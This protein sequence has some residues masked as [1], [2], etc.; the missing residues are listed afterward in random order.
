MMSSNNNLQLQDVLYDFSME[1]E[2]DKHTL[3]R[4]VE[5]Y[6]QFINELTELSHELTRADIDD[7][8]QLTDADEKLIEKA[9]QTHLQITQ[10]LVSDPFENISV[11]ELRGISSSLEVPRS[12]VSAFRDRKVLVE[13]VP[14]SFIT[15]FA[16]ALNQTMEDFL[17]YL[18]GTGGG[19]AVRSYKSSV[20]PKQAE[21]VTFEELLEQS[22]VDM[23]IRKK[24]LSED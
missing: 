16:G 23:A 5:Q 18:N 4:Y 17:I 20:K 13:S 10:N 9:W 2:I 19:T 3:S 1:P 22:E 12:V 7:G 6:P 21:R 8:V 15:R 14:V 24:L 11:K